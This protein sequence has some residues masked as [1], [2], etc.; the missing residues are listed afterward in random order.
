MHLKI[1]KRA[2][3]NTINV[4]A[5]AISSQTPLPQLL[6]FRLY[7]VDNYLEVTASD[8]KLSI[9]EKIYKNEENNF[10]LIKEGG[11]LIDFRYLS[12]ILKNINNTILEIEEID[13]NYIRFLSEDVEYKI[14]VLKIDNYPLIDFSIKEEFFEFETKYLNEIINEISFAIAEIDA[15]PALTGINFVYKDNFLTITATDSYRLGRKKIALSLNKEFNVVIPVKFF[16]ELN[17]I[18]QNYEKIMI[19]LDENKIQAKIDN[20]LVQCSLIDDRYPD[21]SKIFN[22]E[23]NLKVK[24]DARKLISAIEKSLFIR[25]EGRNVVT[26][27][28]NDK[29]INVTTSNQEVGSYNYDVEVIEKK[30]QTI[31]ILCSGKYLIDALKAFG[32]QVVT[33]NINSETK[34]VIIESDSNK[35]LMQLISLIRPH[36]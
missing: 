34:P 24:I 2:L 30:G 5:K 9:T 19:A 22:N 31:T 13:T 18:S 17:Q 28:F 8:S 4:C 20:I 16:K 29:N 25:Y 26:L 35:E 10:D 27:T 21:I 14:N 15:K 33:L 12:E 32:N 11:F 1:E 6:N 36:N 3:Q 7:A 23:F